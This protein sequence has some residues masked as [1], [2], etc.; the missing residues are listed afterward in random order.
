[1]KQ[2]NLE[3]RVSQESKERGKDVEILVKIIRHGLRDPKTNMLTDIGRKITREKAEESG[4]SGEDFKYVKAVGSTTGPYAEVEGEEMGRALETAHIYANEIAPDSALNTRPTE[5]LDYMKIVSPAPYNHKAIYDANLPENFDTLTTEEKVGAQAEAQ[6]AVT[7]HV[8]GLT[9]EKADQY[10]KECA[11][12]L[13][14]LLTHYQKAAHHLESGSKTLIPAGNH[15]SFMEF[16]MQAALVRRDAEGKEIRGFGTLEE[17]GGPHSSSEAFSVSVATDEKGNDKPIKL[18]F[19]EKSR[20]DFGEM[21]LDSE[22]VKSLAEF[23]K[24]LHPELRGLRAHQ[25]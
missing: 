9:G 2:S 3:N 5:V 10:K 12:S 14:Y 6:I 4:L 11:G 22:T 24:G 18:T 13:A 8:L 15:G 21:H 7:K 25:E 19:D 1:M 20:P 17:I 23:Y 16:L